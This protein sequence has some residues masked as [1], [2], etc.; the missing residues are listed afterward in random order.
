VL[1]LAHPRAVA[2]VRS[3][4]RAGV[5]V[6]GADHRPNATGFYSRY[7]ARRILLDTSAGYDAALAGLLESLAADGRGGLL[8]P[9]ADTANVYVARHHASLGHSFTLCSPPWSVLGSCMDRSASYALAAELGIATP[10]A[11][12]PEDPEALDRLLPKLDFERADYVLKTRVWDVRADPVRQRHTLAP[13]QDA[14]SFRR[15]WLEI[16]ARA[17]LPPTIERIVPG[18]SDD[19]VGVSLVMD[20]RGEPQV[21]YGIK[22]LHMYTYARGGR[23]RHPYQ[24]GANVYCETVHD[25]E[26]MAAALALVRRI[27]FTGA[28]TV[29]FRRDPATGTLTFIKLDPRV[30]RSTAL[31]ACLGMDVPQA[32]YR[33]FVLGERTAPREYPD[34]VRW[35]WVGQYVAALRQNASARD[36]LT[37]SARLLTL[38][39]RVRAF[40]YL[41][42]RDPRPF[43][44]S[45]I[46]Q[47]PFAQR[48]LR[49]GF[50]RIARPRVGVWPG[51]APGLPVRGA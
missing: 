11:F 31:A 21:A 14:D 1:D 37:E 16:A 12:S 33:T 18:Q 40:G 9:T 42:A 36:L 35:M 51:E 50:Q 2:V 3:L 13:P 25:E 10:E 27:G 48:R 29:E 32:L 46:S 7:L 49:R 17:Q 6:I 22:R 45:M 30:V 20:P 38:L 4:A 15:A 24:M 28:S 26:A 34:G 44:K 5:E 43:V 47:V 8:V 39:P 23:Y 41:S 19:C